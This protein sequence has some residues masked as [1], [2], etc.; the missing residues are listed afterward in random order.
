[1]LFHQ[2]HCIILLIRQ[3]WLFSS[4]VLDLSEASGGFHAKL[5]HVPS[6]RFER[7]QRC[8]RAAVQHWEEVT[9][10]HKFWYLTGPCLLLWSDS[11]FLVSL[12]FL[13]VPSRDGSHVSWHWSGAWTGLLLHPGL[14]TTLINTSTFSEYHC[15]IHKPVVLNKPCFYQQILCFTDFLELDTFHFEVNNRCLTCTVTGYISGKKE[16]K[17]NQLCHVRGWRWVGA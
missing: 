17:I 11:H 16:L 15:E 6:L 13:Q 9:C 1:M 10:T 14:Q 7:P 5:V 12:I 8:W 3:D 4:K 2:I